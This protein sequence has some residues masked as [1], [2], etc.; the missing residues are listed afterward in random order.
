[1]EHVQGVPI[2]PVNGERQLINLAIQLADGLA[3]A[4]AAGVHRDLKP[5][6]VLV[7]PA[8][9]IKI[10]DFGLALMAPG[11]V[12]RS[13]VTEVVTEPGT[14][15]GT[16]AYM[17]PE[18][19]RGEVVDARTDLWSFGVVLYELATGVRPFNGQKGHV[20]PDG[21]WVI[22]MAPGVDEHGT[23]TS[24]IVPTRGG[25]LQPLCPAACMGSWSLDGRWLYLLLVPETRPRRCRHLPFH[26]ALAV[27]HPIRCTQL[28]RWRSREALHPGHTASRTASSLRVRIRRPTRLS[29]R[30]CNATCFGFHF[31][32]HG[33]SAG[34]PIGGL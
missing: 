25:A 17:S 31:T 7:T 1:M 2:R 34:D 14:A 21:T 27:N 22:V 10:L 28:W 6:N 30:T 16:V 23:T 29:G 11:R 9:Q 19:A 13:D 8:G 4:H 33:I 15:L 24:F 26:W 12:G 18:Q 3:A 5:A 32:E 20:S